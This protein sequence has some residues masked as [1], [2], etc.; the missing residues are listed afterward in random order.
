MNKI[1]NTKKVRHGIL[2]LKSLRLPKPAQQRL[3][4]KKTHYNPICTVGAYNERTPINMCPS[5]LNK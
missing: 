4:Y 3:N 5:F 2:L 1:D